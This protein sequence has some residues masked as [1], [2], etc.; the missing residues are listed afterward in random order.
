MNNAINPPMIAPG[1]PSPPFQTASASSGCERYQ[2]V[3]TPLE[4]EGVSMCQTRAP[5][6]PPI[7]R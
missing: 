7:N 5:T 4:G 2:L 1:M 3:V 6:I